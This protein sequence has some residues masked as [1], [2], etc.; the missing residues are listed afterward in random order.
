M[1]R[2]QLR[3]ELTEIFPT[4]PDLVEALCSETER[5]ASARDVLP[6][7][8]PNA[9]RNQQLERIKK[10]T[11]GLWI[12]LKEADPQVLD[13]IRIAEIAAQHAVGGCSECASA[14]TD[15][16][17]ITSAGILSARD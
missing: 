12:A 4:K 16:T 7:E 5:L 3:T 1:M 17:A 11:E 8:P 15:K 2:D 10:A 6:A 13:E 9:Q 14:T